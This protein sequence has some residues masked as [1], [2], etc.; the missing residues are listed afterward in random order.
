MAL[1]AKMISRT[2]AD[3]LIPVEY[4]R[5]II[6]NIPQRSRLLPLMRRLPNMSS[7]QYKI[8]VLS[9]LPVAQFVNGEPNGTTNTAGQKTTTQAEWE[10]LTL[11]AE[12]LAVIV[13]IPESVLD[14]ADY[15]IW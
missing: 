14:D 12:E 7:K 8:P 2:D 4:S 11:T 1:D 13:P 10:G 5:E 9:A 15:D 6:Q 3:A